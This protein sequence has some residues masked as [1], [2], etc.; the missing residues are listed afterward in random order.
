MLFVEYHLT[1]KKNVFKDYLIFLPLI[2]LLILPVMNR[3][4]V[5]SYL[6]QSYLQTSQEMGK[7]FKCLYLSEH[8]RN[9][10]HTVENQLTGLA[11]GIGSDELPQ[12]N[13]SVNSFHS[14]L[15]K[16]KS[17]CTNASAQK[18]RIVEELSRLEKEKLNLI[19]SQSRPTSLKEF[20]RYLKNYFGPLHLASK[21]YIE[22]LISLEQHDLEKAHAETEESWHQGV[23]RLGLLSIVGFII[24]F[25]LV[26]IVMA[27]MLRL[28]KALAE[29]V[30][31][32]KGRD[33]VLAVVSHDLKNPLSSINLNSQILLRKISPDE[34]II[35]NVK[36]IQ[37]SSNVMLNLIQGLLDQAKMEAG[38]FELDLKEENFQDLLLET[39]SMLVP[40][41][42]KKSIQI[43]NQVTATLYPVKCDKK[44]LMQVLSNLIGNAIKFLSDG[45]EIKVIAKEEGSLLKVSIQDNGPGIAE[46][47]IPHLFDRYWQVKKTAKQGT[48]LGLSIVKELI[49]AHGGKVWVE[50]QLNRGTTFLFTIPLSFPQQK[51]LS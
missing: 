8:L 41:A 49:E 16:I 7:H 28:K 18:M 21:E 22:K 50:S 12:F 45:G 31:A 34:K 38:K 13:K 32:V 44:R 27:L 5:I 39:E 25:I 14:N 1:M 15:E 24:S 46:K 40:L 11:L 6:D 35:K 30:R 36:S 42:E 47:D 23:E 48:G 29:T 37:N 2:P 51:T 43:T 4:R 3:N 20:R 33:D 26:T 17:E 9:L 19:S 10:G